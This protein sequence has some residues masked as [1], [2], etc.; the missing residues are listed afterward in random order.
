MAAVISDFSLGERNNTEELLDDA[1]EEDEQPE[2][3]T[4]LPFPGRLSAVLPRYADPAFKSDRIVP[5][6]NAELDSAKR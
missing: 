4:R 2:S 5:P 3:P 6:R 1:L